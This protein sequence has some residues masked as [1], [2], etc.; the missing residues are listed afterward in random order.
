MAKDL[1]TK[2]RKKLPKKSFA[3]PSKPWPVSL[4]LAPL[5]SKRR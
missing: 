2:D 1:S 5:P 4:S 3:L